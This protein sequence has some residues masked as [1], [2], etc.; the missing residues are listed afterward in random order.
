MIS[1]F[2][3]LNEAW[4]VIPKHQMKY[5]A[6][7]AFLAIHLGLG[8]DFSSLEMHPQNVPV[9]HQQSRMLKYRKEKLKNPACAHSFLPH[10]LEKIFISRK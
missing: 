9:A 1:D 5:P 7:T 10:F 3:F 2:P 6:A 4:L 8:E